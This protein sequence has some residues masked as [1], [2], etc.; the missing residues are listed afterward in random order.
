MQRRKDAKHEL[1]HEDHKGHEE[2]FKGIIMTH[3][4]NIFVFFVPFVVHS[5]FSLRLSAFA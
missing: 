5:A 3:P 2:V 1:N 4:A